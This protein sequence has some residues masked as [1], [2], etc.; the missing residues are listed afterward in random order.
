MSR[1]ISGRMKALSRIMAEKTGYTLRH[2]ILE[3]YN[4]LPE[5]RFEFFRFH[6]SEWEIFLLFIDE[7]CK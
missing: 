6:S 2:A 4:N 7:A 3:C 1:N 5:H